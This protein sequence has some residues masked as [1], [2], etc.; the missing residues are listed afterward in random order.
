M[1]SGMEA[2]HVDHEAL[3][4]SYIRALNVCVKDRP[5]DLRVSVHTCRGNFQGGVHFTEGAYDRIAAKLFNQLDVDTF[6]VNGSF[7]MYVPI[8]SLKNSL[9][10]SV[11]I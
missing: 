6:Y 2:A 1:I 7:L 3:L 4:D 9:F 8:V 5:A 11:G 10:C